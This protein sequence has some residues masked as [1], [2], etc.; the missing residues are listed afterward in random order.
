MNLN[1]AMITRAHTHTGRTN[2]IEYF[3]MQGA[4]Q[5]RNIVLCLVYANFHFALMVV[6]GVAWV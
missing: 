5:G 3:T 6:L 1:K 4:S 2:I